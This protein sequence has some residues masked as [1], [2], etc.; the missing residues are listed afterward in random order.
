MEGEGTHTYEM[1]DNPSYTRERKIYYNYPL[2]MVVNGSIPKLSSVKNSN[3]STSKFNMCT[4][5]AAIT[6]CFVI[7][8]SLSSTAIA[9]VTYFNMKAMQSEDSVMQPTEVAS[10]ATTTEMQAQIANLNRDMSALQ[11]E[12][13]ETATQLREMIVAATSNLQAMRGKN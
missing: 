13:M 3:P 4:I 1:V 5:S 11:S 12:L 8:L 7:A 6:I 9:A 2:E 10:N